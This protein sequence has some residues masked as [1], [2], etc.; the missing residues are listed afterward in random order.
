MSAPVLFIIAAVGA[1]FAVWIVFKPIMDDNRVRGRILNFSEGMKDYF[2]L[3]ETGKAETEAALAG[4]LPQAVLDYSYLP[5]EQRIRFR[6]DDVEADYRLRFH[7]AGE[8]SYLAVSRI[9]EER[10]KGNIPYLVNAFFIK[11]LRARPVEYRQFEALFPEESE[12]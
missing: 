2:F 6:K 12:N 7:E 3:L 9:A 5:E 8:K 10:E 4:E 11:N 1:L